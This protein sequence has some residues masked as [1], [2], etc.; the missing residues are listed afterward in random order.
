MGSFKEKSREGI[1]EMRENS[2]EATEIGTGMLEQAEEINAILES[3]ELLDDEDMQAIDK[4]EQGYGQSFDNAF[5]EQ[6]ETA[7]REIENQGE[8]I[9]ETVDS[10][11][12][13]VNSGIS[14][15]EQAEGVSDIGREAAEGGESDLERSKSE[16]EQISADAV[17]V[18]DEVQEQINALKSNLGS[19]FGF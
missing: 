15:L 6:V 3:I 11:I 8:Q 1:R 9:Q 7:E 5:E 17:D 13:N 12:D 16:Y 19:V 14:K 4:A 18:V 10:E 2:L